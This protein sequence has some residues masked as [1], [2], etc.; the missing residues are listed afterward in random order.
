MWVGF[1]RGV[2]ATWGTV[3]ECSGLIPYSKGAAQWGS[4]WTSRFRFAGL[5][6]SNGCVVRPVQSWTFLLRKGNSMSVSEVTGSSS[7]RH[8]STGV[9]RLLASLRLF[10]D[11]KADME[12]QF[13][14]LILLIARRPNRP[15][16]VGELSEATG[17]SYASSSRNIHKWVDLGMLEITEGTDDRRERLV[18]LT[19]RGIRLIQRLEEL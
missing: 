11:V 18:S 9:S 13:L 14:I 15:M 1:C 3:A 4:L 12:V 16:T 6:W 8:P 7:H 10:W 17:L 2:S 19:P 5:S